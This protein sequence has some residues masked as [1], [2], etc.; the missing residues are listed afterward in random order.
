MTSRTRS[1]SRRW[2]PSNGFWLLAAWTTA[3]TTAT[4]ATA[5]DGHDGAGS[6]RVRLVGFASLPADTFASG[7]ASGAND[8]TGQPVAGNGR[9]GPFNGQPVQG[10]SGVQ[11]GDL[12]RGSFVFLSDNGFGAKN[13]SAD[14]L[15]RLHELTPQFS[16]SKSSNSHGHG[17][18][19]AGS[20]G[21]GSFI[22][23]ADPLGHIPF[24]IVN[25][26]STA[27]RLTGADFDIESFVFD[28]R[29]DLW[30]G[31][32]F[33]PFLLHFDATGRLLEAPIA[34]PD[35]DS[36][37]E[38]S[39]TAI[40]RSPDHPLLG[41]ATANLGRSKGFEGMAFSVDRQTL[42]PLLEGSVAGD[43]PNALRI[44]AYSIPARDHDFVGF[45]ALE[46]TSHAIGDFTPVNDHEYLVIERDGGQGAAAAFKK[47]FLIDFEQT[48]AAGFVEKRALV[49]LMNVSDPLDLNGDGNSLF[50]FPFVTIEDVL[51]LDE[52]TLLVANDNNYPFSL[53]RGPDIDNNEIIRLRLPRRLDFDRRLLVD[54]P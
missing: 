19:E 27:R 28:A 36:A 29:G 9:V 16:G 20:V 2:F 10:L 24:A 7:P 37:R 11:F 14:Y 54:A 5:D 21:V 40:V 35:L 12:R 43:P 52:R 26:T 4:I 51:V 48:D 18:P 3:G 8:G 53:G 17:A 30:V 41:A 39:A 42:Y 44:Y 1:T 38:I 46:N 22:Q 31:D 49:D 23:L 25:E 50:T 34:T 47:I 13:N 33:G 45:Y 32:E 6:T 15:L